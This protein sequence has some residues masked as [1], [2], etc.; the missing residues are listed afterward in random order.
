MDRNFAEILTEVERPSPPDGL[1]KAVMYRIAWEREA[2]SLKRRMV[3]YG[4][5]TVISLAAL[6]KS[7][8]AVKIAF[9]TSGAGDLLSLAASD[10]RDVLRNWSDFAS[11]IL[12][13]LPVGSIAAFLSVVLCLTISI[14]MLIRATRP[15]VGHRALNA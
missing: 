12:E 9:D 4:A 7:L 14:R 1:F 8:L 3:L 6:Q 5:A 2:R 15:I 11:G 10:T 13:T